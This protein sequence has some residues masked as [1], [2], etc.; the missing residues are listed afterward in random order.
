MEK[1]QLLG[2]FAVLN[3]CCA[4]YIGEGEFVSQASS[5]SVERVLGGGLF[6]HVLGHQAAGGVCAFACGFSDVM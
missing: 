3:I 4:Q 5:S 1:L 6:A 2:L